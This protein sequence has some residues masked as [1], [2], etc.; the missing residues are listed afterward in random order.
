MQR[1]EVETDEISSFVQQ[2]ANKP[3]IWLAMD[4]KSRQVIAFHFGDRSRKSARRLWAKIPE[5]YRQQAMF[6]MDQ[7]VG[8][9]GVIPA[10]QH[11]A[12]NKLIRKTNHVATPPPAARAAAPAA[13]VA[14][15]QRAATG[16]G[17][18]K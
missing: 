17:A 7:Y 13:P 8:Y 5:V 12:I 18:T 6:Y 14:G 3:W 11:K 10:A 1:L 9:E 4:T 15:F 2:K 16:S